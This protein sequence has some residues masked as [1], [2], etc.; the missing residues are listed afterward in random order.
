[1]D[2]CPPNNQDQMKAINLREELEVRLTVY[3]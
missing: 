2:E 1:M 3:G